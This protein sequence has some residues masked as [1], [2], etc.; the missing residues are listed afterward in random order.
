MKEAPYYAWRLPNLPTPVDVV[1]LV[2]AKIITAKEAKKLLFRKEP[3]GKPVK[4]Q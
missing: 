2:K 4:Q 1:E 3:L